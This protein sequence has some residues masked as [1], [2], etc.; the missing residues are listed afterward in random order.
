MGEVPDRPLDRLDA[1]NCVGSM[2]IRWS[3]GLLGRWRRIP[4]RAADG[5]ASIL[6]RRLGRFRSLT[7]QQTLTILSVTLIALIA[8]AVAGTAITLSRERDHLVQR[9]D[10]I[11]EAVSPSLTQAL[12]TFDSHSAKGVLSGLLGLGDVRSAEAHLTDGVLFAR[13]SHPS[14]TEHHLVRTIG[15]HFFGDLLIHRVPL[16]HKEVVQSL[17]RHEVIG[18]FRL[19]LDAVAVSQDFLSSLVQHCIGLL[20]QVLVVATAIAAVVHIVVTRPLAQLGTAIARIDPENPDRTKL[21][22]PRWHA[23]NELGRLVKRT[24]LLLRHLGIALDELRVTAATDILTG[25]PNRAALI[26]TINHWIA[27]DPGGASRFAL[28]F[29]D[30]DDFKHVNDSLGHEVGDQLLTELATRMLEAVGHDGFVARLGG[31][32]FVVLMGRMEDI[33]TAATLAD[34]ILSRINNRLNFAGQSIRITGSVGI[35]VY[36]DH[37]DTFTALF[38]AADTAMYAAKSERRGS[39]RFFAADMSERALIRL[40]MQ[41]SLRDALETQAFRLDYQPQVDV[42]SGRVVGCEALI[43]WDHEGG[44]VKPSAFIPVAEATHLIIPIG[45]WVLR[46]AGRQSILWSKMGFR[47]RVSVNVSPLQLEQS[48]DF[49]TLLEHLIAKGDLDPTLMEIEVTESIFIGQADSRCALLVTLKKMGF[50]IAMDDF[51]TG[52]SSLSQLQRLPID[53]LKIDQAFT[54]QLPA[55]PRI[56]RVILSLSEQLGLRTIAEGVEAETQRIWLERHRCYTMQGFLFAPAV[57]PTD[58]ETRFLFQRTSST[59]ERLRSGTV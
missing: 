51:G 41:A 48:Q 49:V 17:T 32:E 10:R 33:D 12:W 7:W 27:E 9:T 37:G 16:V 18:S 2:A 28:L 50:T 52:Y 45:T 3:N 13:A 54:A 26:E 58:F 53:T 35:A 14:E 46:T 25:L 5:V 30:L 34:R 8:L 21:H 47:G 23:N 1:T 59:N 22:I 42:I 56:A 55:D 24:D 31:D 29:F 11:I 20:L 15:T 43:R 44:E 19:E 38:R 4:Y 36:P 57:S 6:V 40:Q 39:W